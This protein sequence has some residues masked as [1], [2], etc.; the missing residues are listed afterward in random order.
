MTYHWVRARNGAIPDGAVAQG[1]EG[2]GNGG[3]ALWVCRALFEGGLHPGKVRPGLGAANISWGGKEVQVHE[4]EVLM[5]EGVW[6]N[7]SSGNVP[8]G[9]TAFGHEATG[10]GLFVARAN[11]AGGLHPGKVRH[12]FGAAYIPYGGKEVSEQSYQVLVGP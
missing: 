9:A 1:R 10:E 8:N 3:E 12:G 6:V 5:E 7:A 4:Y 2:P 11:L